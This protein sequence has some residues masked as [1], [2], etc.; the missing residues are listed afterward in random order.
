L[1]VPKALL[2]YSTKYYMECVCIPVKKEI[3]MQVR[4]QDNTTEAFMPEK[5]VVSIVKSGA[6]YKDA[7][8]IADSLSRR[9]EKELS[10]SE[11]RD[12]VHRELKSKGHTASVK[13]W[14]KYEA[15]M[16]QN[17]TESLAGRAPTAESKHLTH[18]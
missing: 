7:R 16:K 17:R 2:N 15:E 9:S 4:K 6:P 11:I 18:A 14:T 10:S 12:H 3:S 8:S 1:H 13:N 5:V